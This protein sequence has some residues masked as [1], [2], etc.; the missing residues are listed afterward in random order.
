MLNP[1]TGKALDWIK[2][3]KYQGWCLPEIPALAT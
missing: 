1:E 3:E 2:G